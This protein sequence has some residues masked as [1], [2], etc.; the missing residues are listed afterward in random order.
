[1]LREA[2]TN[3]RR[4]IIVSESMKPGLLD[5]DPQMDRYIREIPNMVNGEF[6]TF[7][8]TIRSIDPFVFITSGRLLHVKGF[9]I[10]IRAFAE[11]VK[12]GHTNIW[13]KILGKGKEKTGLEKLSMDLKVWDKV[14]F[15]GRV[16]R[17]AVKKELQAANCFVLASR[18]EAFGIVLIEAMATG[19]PVIATRSGGPGKIIKPE[20]GYLV[21]PE[22]VKGLA[23]AMQEMIGKF[24]SFDQKG[25]RK[26]VLNRYEQTGIAGQYIELLTELCIP[27][28]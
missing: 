1:M 24:S 21:D 5:L 20:Y 15:T 27:A 12:G 7:P 11:L 8:A 17:E 6:F 9:D 18:Y 22:N 19:L 3:S 14:I 25:I 13:L 2:Y 10:L 23:Q 16:S 26:G 28:G 4:V